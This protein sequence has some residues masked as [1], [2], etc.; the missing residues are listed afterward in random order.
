M[1]KIRVTNETKWDTRDLR[2]F[3]TAGLK[4]EVGEWWGTYLVDVRTKR[5]WCRGRGYIGRR[6]MMLYLPHHECR[7]YTTVAT[8]VD[9]E[10]NTVKRPHTLDY[11]TDS[12]DRG[13]FARYFKCQSLEFPNGWYTKLQLDGRA[14]LHQLGVTLAHEVE[15]NNGVRGHREIDD[16]ERD[17]AWADCLIDAGFVIRLQRPEPKKPAPTAQE[18]RAANAKKKLAEHFNKL[19]REKKLVAKWKRKVRYYEKAQSKKAARNG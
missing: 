18:R 13:Q 17:V 1:G 5:V 15:H 11:H 8:G 7:T 16:R 4:A 2:R 10:G 14:F 3:I 12:Y 19:Q 9:S 6:H